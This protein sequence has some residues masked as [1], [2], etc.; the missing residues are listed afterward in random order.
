MFRLAALRIAALRSAST[1]RQTS[2]NVPRIMSA[3][4]VGHRTEMPVMA[5]RWYSAGGALS[6]SDIQER[7]F[8]VL[9]DFDKVKQDKLSPTA[10]FVKD[11][12]LDSLD[13]VEVVMAIEEEFSVEIPDDVADNI[14]S[15]GQAID[16]IVGRSDAH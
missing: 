7:I 5:T 11:L 15:V 16:Y 8:Q 12:G 4:S 10:D 9:Q 13:T 6:R 1:F 14:G 2:T 3:V